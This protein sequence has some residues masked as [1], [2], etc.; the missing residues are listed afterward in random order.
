S[1][2]DAAFRAMLRLADCLMTLVA[3]RHAI[4]KEE[5]IG[6]HSAACPGRLTLGPVA[7]QLLD[8]G[9]VELARY[10]DRSDDNPTRYFK[11]SL[12]GLG[13]Y[14]LGPLRDEYAV[15]R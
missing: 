2:S 12:G 5:D 4:T 13:Q 14:Y 15:L 8:G 9:H 1:A 7:H 6:R 3:E 11:N 10:A